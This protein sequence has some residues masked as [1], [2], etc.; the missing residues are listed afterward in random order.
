MEEVM[1]EVTDVDM[2]VDVVGTSTTIP[3]TKK[4]EAQQKIVEEETQTLG[5]KN[6]KFNATTVK[7]LGIMLGN[8]ELQA[9]GLMRRSIM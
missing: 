8:L 4:E 2:D 1:V 3:I 7:S 6:L 5:M 9:T